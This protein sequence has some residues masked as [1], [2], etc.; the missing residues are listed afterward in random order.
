[1]PINSSSIPSLRVA[2]AVRRKKRAEGGGVFPEDIRRVHIRSDAP[3]GADESALAG[4]IDYDPMTG[5]QLGADLQ[6]TEPEPMANR[7]TRGAIQTLGYGMPKSMLY[8]L[9][10]NAIDQSRDNPLPGL[11]R[12]DFTDVPADTSPDERSAFGG[13]GVKAPK[14]GWQPV[15][16]MVGSSLETGSNI[17]GGTALSAPAAS[18]GAG[19]VRRAAKAGL[20]MG[21]AERLARAAEQ[22]FDV[23]TPLYHGTSKDTDFK[24]FKDSRHGT[25][26]TT[27]PAE[28]SMYAKDNDSKNLRMDWSTGKFEH[29]NDADRVL[30]LYGKPL[31]NPYR[32]PPPDSLRTV[33]NYKKAQS[34]WFDTLKRQGYDGWEP[35]NGV[36]VDFDNA[37]LRGQFAP[38]DPKNA[39]KGMI[40][41]AGAADK[42]AAAAVVPITQRENFSIQPGSRNS[43]K[44]MM[45]KRE[46]GHVSL[47]PH[48]DGGW[49]AF[50]TYVRPDYRKQG[51]AS[52]LYDHAEQAMAQKLKP[53]SAQTEDG[54]QLWKKRDPDLLK[55]QRDMRMVRDDLIGEPVETMHG[56][57]KIQSVGSKGAI[58]A[59]D[60][61]ETTS[62]VPASALERVLERKGIILGAGATDKRAAG[63]AALDDVNDALT[64]ERG[65]TGASHEPKQPIPDRGAGIEQAA[66][67]DAGAV[68]PGGGGPAGIRSLPEAQAAAARWAGERKPLEGLPGALKIGEDHFVPGPIGKIHDVAENYMRTV[69]PDRPY[70]PPTK[71]HPVD[72]EHSK[73]IAKAYEEMKHT[74]D[75][76]ATK[77]SYN[78][79]ID[80]TAKQYQAIKQT[81]L[82]IEPIPA[83]APD[84]YAANPRLAAID[85]AD[86]N[87]LWFFPTEG[88]F[89]SKASEVIG[90]KTRDGTYYEV[91]KNPSKDELLRVAR[92]Y[93]T[94]G[95]EAPQVRVMQSGNDVYAWPATYATHDDIG[96]K[97]GI[98]SPMDGR[99]NLQIARG[100][101]LEGGKRDWEPL[102]RPTSDNP[103]LRKTGEK[104][105]DHELLANDMFRVVHDYF[106]HLK[107]GH[108]FRAA[109]ED[110]AW[111]G[112]S[113]MYS[114]LARPAMTTETRGQNSWVNYGPHGD[115]NRTASGADTVYADQKVGLMPEWTMRDR[116]SLPP[117]MSY[118]GTPY[119]FNRFDI[120]K[121]GAGEGNQAYGHGLYFAGHEPVSE[122]YRHQLSVRND[123]L[124]KKY[125]IEDVGHVIGGHLSDAGG[126]AAE[127]VAQYARLRQRLVDGGERDK[128]T[129]NMIRDYDRRIEYL[130][131]PQRSKGHLYQVGIDADP[132]KLLDYD[133]PFVDQSQH[134]QGRVGPAMEE[135]VDRQIDAIKK[136]LEKGNYNDHPAFQGKGWRRDRP[137]LPGVR[138]GL[139]GKLLAL[140]QARHTSFPGKEIYKRIGLPAKSESEGAVKASQRLLEMDIPGLRYKDAGSRAPGQQGS[141]NFV[142]FN[143]NMLRILRQYGVVGIPAAGVLSAD[144]EERRARGGKVA[145]RVV[146]R[147]EGGEVDWS[148]FNRPFGELKGTAPEDTP[149]MFDT[150][151]VKITEGDIERGMNVGLGATTGPVR[152]MADEVGAAAMKVARKIKPAP[153]VIG[154]RSK[155]VDPDTGLAIKSPAYTKEGQAITRDI[156]QA[157]K[158]EGPLDLSLQGHIPGVEQRPM[159]R[160][161]PPRG[162]S[163][164]MADAME[165]PNVRDGLEESMRAGAGVR[166]W[167]HTE[168]IRQEFLQTLGNAE[169]EAAFK[170]YMDLVAATS[171]RSDVPTNIRNASYY[172]TG[173]DPTKVNPYPYGHVA[174][175][176]HKQNVAT[177]SREGGWDVMQ[178][179]KPASF[180]ENL[181]G[182]LEPVTVDTHAFRNIGMRTGDPR[183]L[184]TSFTQAVDPARNVGADSMVSR[185]GEMS[186]TPKGKD[187]VTFRP[188]QLLK[189]GRINME[190]AQRIPSFWSSKPKDNEYAA[191][192]QMFREIGERV[193]MRPADAQAAAWAGGGDMTGL[194]TVGTHTFPELMNERVMFTAKMRGEE[195]KS[196]LR[197]FITGKKPLLSIAGLAALAPAVVDEVKQRARG[198]AVNTA[199][200]VARKLKRAKGGK[201]HIGPIIGDTDGRADEVP[202]EVPDGAYV[203]TADHCSAMGEGNTLSGFKKLNEMFPKSAQSRTAKKPLNRAS[204]GKVPIYAA[205]GEYVICPEDIIERWGD[206]DEGHRILDAW[207]T[208]ERKEH[209]ETLKGLAPPAQD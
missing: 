70:T 90:Q 147:A 114:D 111:R 18:L 131:D 101:K 118:H 195:P 42:R 38:Y 135:S 25:W 185:L 166:N 123:P 117:I 3:T 204:G 16:P 9:P 192:E 115:K 100:G 72:P 181:R 160:Y 21:E 148:R 32:G 55:S 2:R 47:E 93:P 82:K 20:E 176:L 39:G 202:M 46:I 48:P 120:R 196:V 186:T 97:L 122:W 80:E 109:G 57:G 13:I 124:L 167:Y 187:V 150:P 143:D 179:P 88:G 142:M 173:V 141:H 5:V 128:A 77:A 175:N 4:N 69:H 201:V 54:F 31:Q 84:P 64:T 180:A 106:G 35:G 156:A 140:E 146:R 127:L 183:F 198:G 62:Y 83:G 85:V 191:A 75:D 24:K 126:D 174:Q 206:L 145:K 107:Q 203:L 182:N 87:H 51:V 66:A 116:G 26:T 27:D 158:G 129:K 152:R 193:G 163:A 60:G 59:L 119:H 36:R 65:L 50:G 188:Q 149:V 30:P 58:V 164:R 103:M 12:E 162:V 40:L 34:D 81:G 154:D 209:V 17:M 6:R 74:P 41:G 8:D 139:E 61:K 11:R 133:L 92:D 37:N 130:T 108:G 155:F 91:L 134:V 33:D 184:E 132:A 151:N 194:G 45:G 78:A 22:G 110:N 53:S 144:G 56:P 112:H 125:G 29:V 71:Y 96:K 136:T 189:D 28:A 7:F 49:Q 138:A 1:M 76:P 178:N 67:A 121:I 98:K 23:N 171:P 99:D 104:I 170:R 68:G 43:F 159:E 205:D 73:A 14:V 105:G 165:N 168:P 10:K 63:V 44:A 208:S 79:L 153:A 200:D 172:Y 102:F 94:M 177:V 15:D 137:L 89:G 207:Q 199:M 86:N 52:A 157:P 197:D 113:A 161:V 190:E 169:G 19:P 95:R